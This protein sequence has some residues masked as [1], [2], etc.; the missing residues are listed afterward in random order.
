VFLAGHWFSPDT[1]ISFTNKTER[2]DM[3]EI[4]LKLA[5]NTITLTLF[6]FR[7]T[8]VHPRLLVGFVLCDLYFYLH[9]LYIVC[10]PFVLFLL[11]IVFSVILLYTDSGYPSGV[12]KLG[13]RYFILRGWCTSGINFIGYTCYDARI[14]IEN[15]VIICLLGTVVV[16]IVW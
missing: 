3:A 13:L 1:Q 5:L 12:F 11:S 14:F 9:V 8:W 6:D 10:W 2:L 7:S 4:L 15:S 16:V